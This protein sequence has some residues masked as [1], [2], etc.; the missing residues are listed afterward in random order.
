VTASTNPPSVRPSR[1]RLLAIGGVIG[2]AASLAIIATMIWLQPP[3]PAVQVTIKPSE[4]G[5]FVA[6]EPPRAV[7]DLSFADARGRNVTSADFRGRIVLL[8]LWAT[9]CAPCVEEMPALDRLQQ[10]FPR[11]RFEIIAV[12]ID[13]E[14]ERVVKPFYE[15][16]AL[17]NLALHVDP[18]GAIRRGF[19]VQGLPT[20][21]IIDEAG[22]ERGRVAGAT[23]WDSAA[24]VERIKSWVATGEPR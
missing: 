14:G 1:L 22:R 12:S 3:P 21:I 8:N 18:S 10:R 2:V 16:L 6:T 17:R 19:D 23:D 5:R 4:L 24:W 11:E 13:R 9:W 7:P 15:K 20:T